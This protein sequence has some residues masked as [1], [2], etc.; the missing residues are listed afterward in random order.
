MKYFPRLLLIAASIPGIAV[1]SERSPQGVLPESALTDCQKAGA[2]KTAPAPQTAVPVAAKEEKKQKK[3]KTTANAKQKKAKTTA[4]AKLKACED[5]LTK[6]HDALAKAQAKA[7]VSTELAAKVKSLETEVKRLREAKMVAEQRLKQ[8]ATGGAVAKAQP[9]DAAN[10]GSD[11]ASALAEIDKC[12]LAASQK[13]KSL[14]AAI[15]S[16]QEGKALAEKR[17]RET[18][19]ELVAIRQEM[20]MV[21]REL[22]TMQKRDADHRQSLQDLETRLAGASKKAASETAKLN[23]TAA[24]L[25]EWERRAKRAEDDLTKT[26]EAMQQ[27]MRVAADAKAL[28][29]QFEEKLTLN[30]ASLAQRDTQVAAN[31]KALEAAKSATDKLEKQLAALRDSRRKLETSKKASDDELAAVKRQLVTVQKAADQAPE[32]QKQIDA[33]KIELAAKTKEANASKQELTALTK[34]SKD[35]RDRLDATLLKREELHDTLTILRNEFAQF[36]TTATAD[37]NRLAQES[38]NNLQAALAKKDRE[39]HA[40]VDQRQTQLGDLRRSLQAKETALQE[41][42]Q[43]E[44]DALAKLSALEKTRAQEGQERQKLQAILD[45]LRRDLAA[46]EKQACQLREQLEEL[47]VLAAGGNG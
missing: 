4:S 28:N 7:K 14:A 21:Q 35:V 22:S 34:A 39:W 16:A 18:G 23:K 43:R 40:E 6:A 13:T 3:A 1:S 12:L 46:S 24:S 38:T 45:R 27:S 19:A 9:S 2:K 29:K 36:R 5:A 37:R 8:A 15:K 33:Y 20:E 11:H 30:A 31:G 25:A 26:R 44:K 17:A 42:Y 47:E 32:L 10:D 41:A